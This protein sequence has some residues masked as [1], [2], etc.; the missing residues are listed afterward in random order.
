MNNFRVWTKKHD[1]TCTPISD[2][3]T[4]TQCK[5]FILVKYGRWPKMC[6]ISACKTEAEFRLAFKGRREQNHK[7]FH[8]RGKGI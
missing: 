2:Y 3:K 8:Y 4:K 1:G 6:I 5:S 7:S